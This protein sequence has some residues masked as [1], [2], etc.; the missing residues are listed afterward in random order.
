MGRHV[1]REI[2]LR[3]WPILEFQR[4]ILKHQEE[5]ARKFKMYLEPLTKDYGAS[6]SC[7]LHS[8][9]VIEHTLK[10]SFYLLLA[11]G[12]LET[13]SPTIGDLYHPMLHEGFDENNEPQLLSDVSGKRIRWVLRYGFRY[14]E[15]GLDGR[16]TMTVKARVLV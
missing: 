13:R 7:I 16:R 8:Q 4:E 11:G 9:R 12:D 1:L 14:K 3:T 15:D 2:Q 5:V 10:L 6:E